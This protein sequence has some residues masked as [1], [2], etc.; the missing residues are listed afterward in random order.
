MTTK[1]SRVHSTDEGDASFSFIDDELIGAFLKN[2]VNMF[3][4]VDNTS[5]TFNTLIQSDEALDAF[6][7]AVHG[8]NKEAYQN[9]IDFATIEEMTQF[10]RNEKK[11]SLLSSMAVK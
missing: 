6:N 7:K 11:K 1:K 9:L 2:S 5:T 4:P 8:P 10:Y 3:V